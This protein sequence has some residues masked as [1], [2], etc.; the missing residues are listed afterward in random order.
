M[1]K[2][3]T[4]WLTNMISPRK[5]SPDPQLN[6]TGAR[7]RQTGSHLRRSG[8]HTVARAAPPKQSLPDRQ[9]DFVD[10]DPRVSGRIEDNGPGKNVLIRSKYVREDTGTHETLKI[11]DDSMLDTEEEAGIDPYNTGQF[12]R[13]RNWDKRR[14]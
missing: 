1:M 3:F 5:A 8:S 13:S 4:N 6:R 11:L 2:R 14:K 12:D 7:L 9:P 10:L